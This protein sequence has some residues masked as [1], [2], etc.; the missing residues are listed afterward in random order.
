[1]ISLASLRKHSHKQLVLHF[2]LG[3]LEVQAIKKG[4]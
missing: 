3:E 1:M 4:Y 2:P